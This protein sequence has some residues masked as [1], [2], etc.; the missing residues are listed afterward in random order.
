[1]IGWRR[2]HDKSL[3]T[4]DEPVHLASRYIVGQ[5]GGGPD[6]EPPT[7]L[8]GSCAGT[9]TT[10]A[11]WNAE[12]INDGS[13]PGAANLGLGVHR[14]Y[15]PGTIVANFMSTAAAG[16]VAN[17]VASIWSCKPPLASVNNGSLDGTWTS[18]FN[19]IPAGHRA[20]IAMWHEPWDDA[21]DWAEY[22]A[23]Q[24]RVWNLLQASEADTHL[25][26]FGIIATSW[27]YTQNRGPLFFPAGGQFD[28]VGADPYDM[29]RNLQVMPAS[30]RGRNDHRSPSTILG[31]TVAFATSVG[32]PIVIGEFGMHPDP[33]NPN[34]P[35]NWEG[36]PSRPHRMAAFMDY[37]AT[38][39]V[40]A[41]TYFHSSNGDDGPWW[42]NCF[43]NFTTKSDMST[44]DPDTMKVWRDYLA[45]YGKQ[46]T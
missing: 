36:V 45:V 17:G 1:M 15:S 35:A 14:T 42:L 22:R 29:Y 34:G 41:A 40:V 30:P 9:P 2:M 26:K 39:N 3:I 31:A 44:P 24:A 25:V 28:F 19:S 43:H 23:A 33:A 10:F 4:D 27:D 46:A 8:L 37:M 6:P 12:C 32:K 20:Y 18:F 11:T 16:D 13:K 7:M 21:F 5:P 38:H